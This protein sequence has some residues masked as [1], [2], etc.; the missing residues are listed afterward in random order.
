MTKPREYQ[1]CS[2]AECPW[3]GYLDTGKCWFH[4][5]GIPLSESDEWTEPTCYPGMPTTFRRALAG[6]T[7]EE[8]REHVLK[9]RL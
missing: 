1:L 8:A 5:L 7:I 2:V 4:S 6:R 9:G 3:R